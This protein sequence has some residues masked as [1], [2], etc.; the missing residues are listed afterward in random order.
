M[1]LRMLLAGLTA[2]TCYKV[3]INGV[4]GLAPARRRLKSASADTPPTELAAL[5]PKAVTS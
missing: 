5:P 4:Q 3:K 1:F 2:L